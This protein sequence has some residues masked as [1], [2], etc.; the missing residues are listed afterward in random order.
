V[1]IK[2][3]AFTSD[4]HS[5]SCLSENDFRVI[6]SR[7]ISDGRRNYGSGIYSDYEYYNGDGAEILGN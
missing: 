3:G 4:A 5:P 2:G 7:L 1:S 6:F